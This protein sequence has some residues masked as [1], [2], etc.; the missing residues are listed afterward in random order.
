[1]NDKNTTPQ[2][3][4]I[5]GHGMVSHRCITDIVERDTARSWN[6]TVLS[7]EKERAYDRVGLS[8]YV[9]KWDRSALALDNNQYEGQDHVTVH[10]SEPAVSIDR[11]QQIVTGRSGE[12]YPYDTLILAT[13]SYAFVPPIS[14]ADTPGC[15]VYRTLD[16]LDN[17]RAAAE[18]HPGTHGVVIGGG[19]LGLEAANALKTLGLTPYIVEHN[20][21]LLNAQVDE[22]GGRVLKK[23][24]HALGFEVLL[25]V[26]T[27]G[28]LSHNTSQ[29]AAE[30]NPHTTEQ[31]ESAARE[32]LTV[33]LSDDSTIDASIVVFSAGIR[34]RDS[35]AREAGLTIADRGGVLTDVHC[36]TSDPHIYAIGEVAAIEGRCY[37]LVGPGYDSAAVV[38][39]QLTGDS[40]ARFPGADMS[41][42]LKLMGVDVASFGDAQGT[43][44]NCIDI[45]HTDGVKGTYA[46]LVMAE[47]EKTLLGGVLVGDTSAYTILKALVNTPLEAEPAAY[48]TPSAEKPTNM[49]LPD[50]AQ[51]CSCNHVTK[52]QILD[53]IE[54]EGAHDVP[55]IKA[56][57]K[58]GTTCGGCVP[59][60]VQ[61]LDSSG[62]EVSQ[63]VCEHFE[64]SRQELYHI[65]QTTG[66]RTFDELIRRYGHGLGCEICKPVVGSILASTSSDN[67]LEPEQASLQDTNDFYM[68]NLQKNGTYSIVPRMPGGE[69]TGEQLITIGQIAQEY[70]LYV[71]CTGGQRI[72]MFGA[73]LEQLPVI[74]ERL[75]DAGME[76]GY[77]YGK[78]MRTVKSCVGSTWCRYGVLDSVGMAVRLEHRYKGLRSPHKFKLAVSG[79]TRECAEARSK[80]FGVIATADGWNLYVCGNGGRNPKHAILFASSI[81]DD[82][83]IT[84]IDRIMMFYIRTAKPLQRTAPWL[85]E[86]EGGIEQLKQ[87]VIEDKLGVCA[88]LDKQ[89]ADHV[90]GYEDEW[91]H[92]LK[93]P[94]K[95][96]RFVSF[97]NAPEVPDETIQFDESTGRKTPVLVGMP[98][99]KK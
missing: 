42:K 31:K 37:G 68:A 20:T 35:L 4:V 15:F 28:I 88:D 26:K 62:V 6:I 74:W 22:G 92:V 53:A 40:Q 45:V 81:D 41:T 76:S 75:I 3:L 82:T 71:K 83:L 49:T 54:K 72:D 73:R 46:K 89:M 13:G 27:T 51:V 90:S 60:I 39:A 80:D 7:E 87:V 48:I 97:I 70:D 32:G 43:T 98:T 63:N 55:A 36:R 96:A 50:D 78:S 24:V 65:I 38:A 5:I 94:A 14:G 64:Y 25:G 84:Y 23:L 30:E 77:A 86:L 61:I 2:N 57:T 56:C 34:P 29:T 52:R 85:E 18:A 12:K 47:D 95:R 69:V 8:G 17:I 58:A 16:D 11:E 79:C 66:I 99:V 9:G 10:L 1:M 33:Q 67:I 44:K 21:R 91:A 59:T 19:L 93:D